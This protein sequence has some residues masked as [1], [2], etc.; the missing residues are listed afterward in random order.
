MLSQRPE[1]QILEQIPAKKN[2]VQK[3]NSYSFPANNLCRGITAHHKVQEIHLVVVWC[4]ETVT[5][6][7][8]TVYFTEVFKASKTSVNTDLP[9]IVTK[10]FTG[11]K[12]HWVI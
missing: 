11:W 5:A 12:R 3:E 4:S 10:D 8:V 1:V 2:T 6:G 9:G 7:L